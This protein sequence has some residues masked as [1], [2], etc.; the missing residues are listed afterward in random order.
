MRLRDLSGEFV[1]KY[2]PA[3]RSHTRQDSLDGAQ[4]VMFQCPK[5]ASEPGCGPGTGEPDG[6]GCRGVHYV[7]CWFANPRNAPRVPDD[8]EP[9]PGR[10]YVATE[11]T[12]LDDLTFTGPGA[13]SV[14]LMGGCNWHG[15][16][17]N[18]DAT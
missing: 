12:G 3:T 2:D 17:R 13:C 18:G 8:A 6:K 5:C 10:W 11:S 7:L 14:L 4:G 1:G 16:I 15:F 9:K